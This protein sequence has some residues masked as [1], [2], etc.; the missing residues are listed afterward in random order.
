MY[1]LTVVAH[2]KDGMAADLRKACADLTAESAD[3]QG[4]HHYS[5]NASDDTGSLVLVEVHEN[6]ASIFNHIELA[7]VDALWA[8]AESF[9]DINL[10]GPPASEKL[11]ETLGAVGPMTVHLHI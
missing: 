9:T 2:P 7:Q 3:H 11:V 5:W 4:L 6:E 1:I 8:A 10:Y